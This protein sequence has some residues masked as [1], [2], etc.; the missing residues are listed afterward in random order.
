[1]VLSLGFRATSLFH[2][3]MVEWGNQCIL[4]DCDSVV[5]A[6]HR[7]WSSRQRCVSISPMERRRLHVIFYLVPVI[8]KSH[9]V[10]QGTGISVFWQKRLS[11]K[12]FVL[13]TFFWVIS[14]LFFACD[15]G[16]Y[17]FEKNTSSYLVNENIVP[18]IKKSKE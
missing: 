11:G 14:F 17:S 9:E 6:D 15:S 4:R 3:K 8:S 16:N 12:C 2:R 1:M 13:E 5:E 7:K 10:Y 18:I